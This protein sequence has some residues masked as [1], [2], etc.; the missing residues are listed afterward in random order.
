MESPEDDSYDSSWWA[1][2]ESGPLTNGMVLVDRG[3]AYAFLYAG[4]G[5]ITLGNASSSSS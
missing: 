4:N 2:I 3:S 5:T 1:K